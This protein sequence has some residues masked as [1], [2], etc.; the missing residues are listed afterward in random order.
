MLNYNSISE[1]ILFPIRATRHENIVYQRFYERR[2]RRYYLYLTR[3][4]LSE[5]DKPFEI[6]RVEFD[7]F[8]PDE[9]LRAVKFSNFKD[10]S[11]FSD[12][13]LDKRFTSRSRDLVVVARNAD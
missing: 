4:D 10:I 11:R 1:E 13:F 3:M 12:L 2:G 9:I 8:T 6:F 5:C 7:N